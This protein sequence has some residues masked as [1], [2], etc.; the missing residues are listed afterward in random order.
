MR[1]HRGNTETGKLTD[2]QK[3]WQAK[4]QVDDLQMGICQVV[5]GTDGKINAGEVTGGTKKRLV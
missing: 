3:Q 4:G 5:K 1:K 2:R